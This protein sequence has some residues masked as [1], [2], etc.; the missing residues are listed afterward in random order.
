MWV[1]SLYGLA[2]PY[3][4]RHGGAQGDSQGMS[5]F[6]KISENRME[7][8]RHVV[9]E[10][11]Y[12]EDRR[13]GAPDSAS[14]VPRQPATSHGFLP[15]VAFSDD[16]RHFALM[17]CGLAWLMGI[18][19]VTCAAACGSVQ[20]GKVKVYH[21]VLHNRRLHYASGTLTTSLGLL[22]LQSRGFMLTGIPLVMGEHPGPRIAKAEARL[23]KIERA[24]HCLRPAY[25]LVLRIVHTYIMFA[26]D[27][28]YKAMPSCPTRLRRT[29]GAAD[30]VLTRAVRVPRNVPR[31]LLLMP[32]AGGRFSSPHLYSR[33]EVPHS[34]GFAQRARSP[35]CPRPRPP[36]PLER[37]RLP[38]PRTPPQHGRDPPSGACS[39]CCNGTA[40]GR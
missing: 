36:K 25:V 28:V 16:R 34:H 14:Y 29:Q 6:S 31:A 32:V 5:Y 26:L 1:T 19:A 38:G 8:L 7:H 9:R 30:R 10:G 23:A 37:P 33:S 18:C 20:V 17:G 4:L 39:P 21:L 12:P 40:L 35:K 13:P 15:E 3:K 24:L 2:V 27:Y 11:V 22:P